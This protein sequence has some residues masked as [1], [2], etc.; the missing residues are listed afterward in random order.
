M[1][2]RIVDFSTLPVGGLQELILT[3]RIARFIGVS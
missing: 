3:D 2:K 1:P